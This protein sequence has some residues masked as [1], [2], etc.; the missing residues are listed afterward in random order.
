MA[1]YRL[2]TTKMA[3]HPF[4]VES[5]SLNLYSV[6]ELCF[7]LYHNPYLMDDTIISTD[8]TKWLSEELA[9]EQTALRMEQALYENHGVWDF[10]RPLFHDQHYLSAAE[11]RSYQRILNAIDLEPVWARVRKKADALLN[12]DKIA[13]AVR[14]YQKILEQFEDVEDDPTL[15]GEFLASVWFHLGVANMRLFKYEEGSRAFYQ[16]YQEE[17]ARKT[18]EAYLMALKF[19]L[20]NEKYREKT[21]GM[22]IDTELLEQVDERYDETVTADFGIVL[23][24]AKEELQ[25]VIKEYRN[26][27]G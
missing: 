21:E 3:V 27:V 10:L 13:E 20:P 23:S 14:I 18:L 12:H 15:S 6:E 1:G 24:P 8:L 4:F 17:P 19:A 5:V 16:S 26:A 7:F 11:L 22:E 2:C 25:K 9:L